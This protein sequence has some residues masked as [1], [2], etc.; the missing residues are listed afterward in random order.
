MCEQFPQAEDDPRA[1]E[2]VQAHKV[3]E[4]RMHGFPIP[5]FATDDMLDGA[6]MWKDAIDSLGLNL[7]IIE[8]GFETQLDIKIAHPLCFG[9]PDFWAYDIQQN[10]IYIADYKYGHRHVNEYGNYQMLEYAMGVWDLV[11]VRA[12]ASG[13]KFA[14][15]SVSMTIV[16]PRSFHKSGPVR[17][18]LIAG[19]EFTEWVGKIIDGEKA[20]MEPNAYC[21]TGSECRDCSARHACSALQQVAQIEVEMSSV[22][23]PFD[24]PEHAQGYELQT[25][26]HAIS[27]MEARAS[28]LENEILAKVKRGVSIRGWRAEQGQGRERWKVPVEE[29]IALGEMMGI[30]VEKKSA[31]T[32]KQAIKKGLL[33]GVVAEY[34]ETPVGEIKLVE[35]TLEKARLIFGKQ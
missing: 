24:M 6:E 19:A 21:V 34:A 20:A 30:D 17:T 13:H 8:Y 33:P 23:A 35:D 26:R 12:L 5:D 15:V 9:T 28:G 25:L 31:I 14:D 3:C 10:R 29:V 27:V 4:A 11:R 32:P 22:N 2:G 1:L 16:Q 18:W 7:D